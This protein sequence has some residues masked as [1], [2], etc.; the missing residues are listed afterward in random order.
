[1]ILLLRLFW[2]YVPCAGCLAVPSIS[3]LCV[4]V[5][6]THQGDVEEVLVLLDLGEGGGDVGV[7]VVPPKAEL[8]GGHGCCWAERQ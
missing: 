3:N 7:E 2:Q 6:V 8:L 5:V 4:L 1:M